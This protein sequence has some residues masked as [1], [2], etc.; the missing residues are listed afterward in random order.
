MRKD[1]NYDGNIKRDKFIEWKTKK[2]EIY[3]GK[4][5]KRKIMKEEFAVVVK[6]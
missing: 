2:G 1:K 3:D 4:M 6:N 5:K